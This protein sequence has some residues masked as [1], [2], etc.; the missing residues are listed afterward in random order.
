MHKVEHDTK[1]LLHNFRFK[2]HKTKSGTVK[3]YFSKYGIRIYL[4]KRI[5]FCYY[6]CKDETCDFVPD[7]QGVF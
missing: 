6:R 4:G 3:M 2:Y 7:F 5:T 1:I